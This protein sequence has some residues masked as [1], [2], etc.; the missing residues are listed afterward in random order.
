MYGLAWGWTHLTRAKTGHCHDLKY[1][2]CDYLLHCMWIL[3][4]SIILCYTLCTAP[5]ERFLLP[6]FLWH[7]LKKHLGYCYSHYDDKLATT[8]HSLWNHSKHVEHSS[9][10]PPS[11]VRHMQNTFTTSTF[12]LFTFRLTCLLGNG[13][14]SP[15]SIHA[16]KWGLSCVVSNIRSCGSSP[17]IRAD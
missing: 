2:N 6:G 15:L 17:I 3:C 7:I 11:C 13:S 4:Q 9:I 16:S 8:R 12:L 1:F 5:G 14:I 10:F